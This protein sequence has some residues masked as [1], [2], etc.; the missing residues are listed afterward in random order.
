VEL[1]HNEPPPLLEL[2]KSHFAS[3]HLLKES[4]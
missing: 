3:C 1:C 2:G 4:K